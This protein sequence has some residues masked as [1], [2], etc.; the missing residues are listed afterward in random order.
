MDLA[1]PTWA[2]T[3]SR[4]P[5]RAEPAPTIYDVAAAAGVATSTVSRAFARPGRV[6]AE[7][8]ARIHAV[9]A[10]LGY[11]NRTPAAGGVPTRRTGTI[12]L[13]VPDLSNPALVGIIRGVQSVAVAAGFTVTVLDCRESATL[14]RDSV[15]QIAAVRRRGHPGGLQNGEPRHPQSGRTTPA[16]HG[17]SHRP[18][19]ARHRPRPHDR[20]HQ[21]ATAPSP[22]RPR[23]GRLRGGTRR[24]LGR[25]HAVA[26][27]PRLRIRIGTQNQPN[28][29]AAPPRCRAAR[30]PGNS[31]AA[32]PARPRRTGPR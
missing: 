11:R 28:R 30:R 5:R 14:E 22:T 20:N 1:P 7:T 4:A 8:A 17:R 25:Q 3:E 19:P 2:M 27:N 26:H 12:A 13:A 32:G 16:D 6:S 10:E 21:R 29:T 18:R 23:L 15:H 9:A 31:A 24:I